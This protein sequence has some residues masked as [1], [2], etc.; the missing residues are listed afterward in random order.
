MDGSTHHST[1]VAKPSP[2][3]NSP[4]SNLHREASIY[5]THESNTI[6]PQSS[7]LRSAQQLFELRLIHTFASSAAEMQTHYPNEHHVNTSIRN[8]YSLAVEPKNWFLMDIVMGCTAISLRAQNLHDQIL[9]EAS[10]TYALRSIQECSRQIRQGI[11]ASN[12]WLTFQNLF[13]IGIAMVFW[14]SQSPSPK[15]SW[16]Y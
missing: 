14:V 4:V 13:R 8:I 5:Y 11:N 7:N 3:R 12:P 1:I 16:N 10:H 9:I 2:S 6:R 15:D